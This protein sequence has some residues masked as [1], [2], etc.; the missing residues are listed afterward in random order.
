MRSRRQLKLTFVGILIWA[1]QSFYVK[2]SFIKDTKF[3]PTQ[4]LGVLSNV[5]IDEASGMVASWRNPGSYW[6]INDSEDINRIFLVDDAGQGKV[7]FLI[8]GVRNRDWEAL[9]RWQNKT[10]QTYIYIADIGDNASNQSVYSIHRFLEPSIALSNPLTRVINGTQTIHFQ[11][12]DGSRDLECLLVDQISGDMFVI[13]KRE[14][15]KHLYRIPAN[16]FTNEDKLHDAEFIRELNFS[17]PT[18]NLAL[19]KQL[20]FITGGDVAASNEEVVVR[21]YL[22]IYY[23]KKAKNESLA[24]ALRRKPQIVPSALEPQGEAVAFDRDGK[25]YTTIS[26]I[27]HFSSPAHMFYTP[28][29]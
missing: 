27:A 17:V 6:V 11:L 23:W 2:E 16:A 1:S 12:L 10:G 3:A 13:S 19:L 20:Y 14:D 21:N 5:E 22:E 28:K 26:E 15:R 8:N 9:G 29:K 25:G 4:D 24:D 7:E 18:S